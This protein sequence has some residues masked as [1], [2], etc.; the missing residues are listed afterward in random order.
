MTITAKPSS[1]SF[2][3]GWSGA[4]SGSY[5]VCWLVMANDATVEAEFGRT[6][7]MTASHGPNGSISPEGSFNA[8]EGTNLSFAITAKS[9]YRVYDV[10]VD[11]V[12]VG[13][14]GS[15]TFR[16]IQENHSIAARFGK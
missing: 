4:C 1:N 16:G 9:G 11:G 13:A 15:Y 7:K 14:V 8:P 12:S 3:N 5:P 6:Y 2:F 10:H